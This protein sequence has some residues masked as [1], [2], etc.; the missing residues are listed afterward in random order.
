MRFELRTFCAFYMV[1]FILDATDE[2][3]PALL[4]LI[5]VAVVSL[6][7]LRGVNRWEFFAFLIASSAYILAVHFPNPGNH[8]NIY[9]LVNAFLIAAILWASRRPQEVPDDAVL[10]EK[11]KPT[12]RVTMSLIYI[13]AGLAKLNEGFLE[14]DVGCAATFF[15]G[16]RSQVPVPEISLAGVPLVLFGAFIIFWE[17]GGGVMLWFRKTQPIML[18]MA[19]VGHSAL[20]LLVFFDFSSLAFAMLLTF[21]P[22]AYWQIM[23]RDSALISWRGRRLD[24]TSAYVFINI[25]VALVAGVLIQAFGEA[26]RIHQLQGLGLIFAVAV[27]LWPIFAHL[28]RARPPVPWSGVPIWRPWPAPRW[29]VALPVFVVF[30]G[31]NPYLGLRTAGTFTMFSNLQV[32]GDSSNHLLLGDQPLEIFDLQEDVVHVRKIDP[33]HADDE[34]DDLNGNSIPTLEFQKLIVE[35]GDQGLDRLDATYEYEGR[36]YE[37]TDLVDDNAWDVDGYRLVH[38]LVDFRV[39]QEQGPV[40][41]RW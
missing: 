6:I 9:L 18:A 10:L 16:L 12:L 29:A 38:Y 39:V 20:A 1:A 37:T 40:D 23:E 3:D 4:A 13:F 15:D 22:P 30:F 14:D 11:V 24:R 31:L 33:R 36:V 19:L 35:W 41:C 8:N 34:E 17:L 25:A 28:I 27:F 7:Y 32:E 26:N 2:W 21:V 5:S